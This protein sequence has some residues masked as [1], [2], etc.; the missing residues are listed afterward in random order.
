MVLYSSGR[1]SQIERTPCSVSVRSVW[2]A[3]IRFGHSVVVAEVEVVTRRGRAALSLVLGALRGT[4]VRLVG[5]VDMRRNEIW[6][7]FVPG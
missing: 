7:I 6:P 4:S 1:A 2:Y 3:V 5:R